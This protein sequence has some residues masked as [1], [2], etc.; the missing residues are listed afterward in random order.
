MTLTSPP[1]DGLRTYGSNRSGASFGVDE[2]DDLSKKLYRVTKKGGVCV[3]VAGDQTVKGSETGTSFMI[4]LMFQD[5]GWSIHDTMI[6]LKPNPLPTRWEARR[7][8]QAFEYMFVFSK[9]QPAYFHPMIKPNQHRGMK[10]SGRHRKGSDDLKELS[11][12]GKTIRQYGIESNVWEIVNSGNET[13]HPAV[14]PVELAEQ[15]IFT[16]TPG[17]PG[18]VI[19]DPFMGSGTTGLAAMRQHRDFLGFELNPEYAEMAR[20]RV[21]YADAE[22]NR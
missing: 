4:A 22:E 11:G 9:G 2:I 12:N 19:F 18:T 13:G 7:Y 8:T 20:R 3:W 21:K 17:Y 1:Y 5:K 15:H 16:W 14:F 6:W 10:I